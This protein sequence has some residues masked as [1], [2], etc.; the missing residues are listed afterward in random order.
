MTMKLVCLAFVALAGAQKTFDLAAYKKAHPERF[1]ARSHQHSEAQ[2]AAYK[3]AHP[4]RFER[5]GF[6]DCQELPATKESEAA[7]A[8]HN[9]TAYELAIF[10]AGMAHAKQ[11]A[12]YKAAHPNEFTPEAIVA[13]KEAHP[14]RMAVAV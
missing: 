12:G 9:Y 4:E 13:Y 14:G 2:I 7:S 6:E 8:H 10:V 1:A 5:F 3:A 11:V